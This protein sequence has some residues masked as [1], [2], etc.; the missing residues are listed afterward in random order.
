M[1]TTGARKIRL[2]KLSWGKMK[3]AIKTF[4]WGKL[5]FKY[6]SIRSRLLIVFSIFIFFLIAYIFDIS[7]PRVSQIH[8]KAVG[9]LRDY[10]R[11]HYRD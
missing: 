5:H 9:L 2:T 6:R 10:L 4:E 8:G 7:I 3:E 11:R 1:D